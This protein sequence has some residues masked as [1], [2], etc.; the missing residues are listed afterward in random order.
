MLILLI[1]SLVVWRQQHKTAAALAIVSAQ[2]RQ[3]QHEQRKTTEALA[4]VQNKK[5]GWKR[6]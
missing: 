2:K 4:T 3:L 1:T 5:N 6:N